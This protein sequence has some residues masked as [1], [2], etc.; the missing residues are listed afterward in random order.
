[1]DI[2]IR[3]QADDFFNAYHVLSEHN[4][5]SF[6]EMQRS[7]GKPR[8][9]GKAFGSFPTMSP[10]VVCLAF[11]VE[12]YIKDLHFV[13]NGKAP[14]GHNILRLYE[15]LPENVKNDV[16]AHESINENPFVARGNAL[17]VRRFSKNYTAYDGFI[18]QLAAI[19]NGFEKWRY[20]HESAALQYEEW[21][22]LVLVEAVKSVADTIRTRAAV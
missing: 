5:A 7:G 10:S 4:T 22:A 17:S 20:S 6:E 11:A 18:D 15:K 8:L 2:K 13:I 1:M 9:S 3:L 19:S 21:F 16:Y 14:R 12:L